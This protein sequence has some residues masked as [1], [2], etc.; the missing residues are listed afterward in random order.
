MIRSTLAVAALALLAACGDGQPFPDTNA[1][2]GSGSGGGTT[3]GGGLD[4]DGATPPLPGTASPSPNASIVRFE[5]SASDGGS[6]IENVS[7]NA[8]NDTFSVDGV[9]FDGNNVYTRLPGALRTVGPTRVFGADVTTPDAVTN[10]PID[11]FF[12]Y[13]AMYGV[14]RN[15][16]GDEPRTSFA[17]VRTGAY[18][19]YGFGGYVYQRNGGVNL[20]SSGQAVFKGDYAGMRVFDGRP[21]LEY[22]TGDMRMQIDFEDFNANDAVYARIT[23]RATIDEQGNVTAGLPSVGWIVREGTPVITANGEISGEMFSNVSDGQ[24]G[25]TEYETGTFTG[26]IAGDLTSAPGGE[27]VGVVVLEAQDPNNTSI[28]SQETGGVVLYR[29]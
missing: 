3:D 1:G 16:A 13:R 10:T 11:Q 21:G 17:I 22:T 19:G 26:I 15:R 24:G 27:I 7:Y 12:P 28:S 23:N 14:S 2:N 5:A 6:L 29:D 4:T 8:A 9:G 18:R 20:P 25:F